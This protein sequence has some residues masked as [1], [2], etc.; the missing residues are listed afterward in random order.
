MLVMLPKTYATTK[1]ASMNAIIGMIQEA[2][3]NFFLFGLQ[4]KVVLTRFCEARRG[5]E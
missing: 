5:C 3:F 4:I 1:S 2:E